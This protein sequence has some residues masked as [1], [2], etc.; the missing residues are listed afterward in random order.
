MGSPSWTSDSKFDTL[1]GRL[2]NQEE[3]DKGIEEWT[4]TL[5][6]YEIMELCQAAGVPSMP[7]QSSQDRVDND[8]QLRHREMYKDLEHPALGV[9]P[10]QNAPFKMSETPAYTDPYG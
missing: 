8:P 7:V 6:K 10:L 5:G 3:L 2:A 1:Q 4:K 9:W